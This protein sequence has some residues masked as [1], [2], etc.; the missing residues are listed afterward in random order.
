MIATNIGGRF[1][2]FEMFL[3]YSCLM[4]FLFPFSFTLFSAAKCVA[5]TSADVRDIAL[6]FGHIEQLFLVRKLCS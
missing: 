3:Y 4:D 2:I 6:L 5:D 1:K